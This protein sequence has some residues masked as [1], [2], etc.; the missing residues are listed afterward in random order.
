MSNIGDAPSLVP[1]ERIF[2]TFEQCLEWLPD[3]VP[4]VVGPAE[5]I[6]AST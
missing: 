3:N 6:P 2:D 1:K 5:A 4:D